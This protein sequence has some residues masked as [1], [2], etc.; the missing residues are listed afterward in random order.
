MPSG[1]TARRRTNCRQNARI[2]RLKNSRK[3][4]ATRVKSACGTPLIKMK[5]K[6]LVLPILC[7]A[8]VCATRDALA[9]E[10]SPKPDQAIKV[11]GG[12]A[13]PNSWT[14]RGLVLE[15]QKDANG[16]GVSGDPCI[17]WDEAIKGWRMVFFHD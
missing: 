15:R 14:R 8:S 2:G 10:G 16:S 6:F 4:S 11:R 12:F 7:V 3:K 17:V 9:Q 1:S 5:L 13:I